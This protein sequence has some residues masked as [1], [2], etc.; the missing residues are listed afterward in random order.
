[1]GGTFSGFPSRPRGDE[2]QL[3]PMFPRTVASKHLFSSDVWN[4]VGKKG[5]SFLVCAQSQ[6]CLSVNMSASTVVTVMVLH[7]LRDL[8]TATY[9]KKGF[10]EDVVID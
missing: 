6:Y 4:R 3:S 2:T 5:T 7:R 1:M 8:A 10:V 9:L